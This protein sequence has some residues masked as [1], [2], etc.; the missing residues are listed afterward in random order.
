M[1][2]KNLN[3]NN[4][5]DVYGDLLSE[6]KIDLLKYY[7]EDDYS[8]SE[9]SEISEISR[10]GV[11]DSVK[12]SADE[13]IFFDSVLKLI[14]KKKEISSVVNEIRVLIDN[15]ECKEKIEVLL[16]RINDVL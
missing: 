12:K 14:D 15:L 11:R 5:I 13:L 3:I 6:K 1:F 4:L 10:Q 7:Y 8:L 2:S 16:N 9:I